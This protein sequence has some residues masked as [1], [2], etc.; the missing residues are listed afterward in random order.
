LVN[1]RSNFFSD[2]IQVAAGLVTDPPLRA[3]RKE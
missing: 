3:G 2:R 1:L